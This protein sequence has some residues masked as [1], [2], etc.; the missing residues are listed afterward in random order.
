MK[1]RFQSIDFHALRFWKFYTDAQAM[2][3]VRSQSPNDDV[4]VQRGSKQG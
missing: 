3:G 4:G 2:D 1:E